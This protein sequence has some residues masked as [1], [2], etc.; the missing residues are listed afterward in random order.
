VNPFRWHLILGP[1]NFLGF[2]VIESCPRELTFNVDDGLLPIKF[3]ADLFPERLIKSV[4][5]AQDFTS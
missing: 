4:V 2:L 5:R 3:L 1:E